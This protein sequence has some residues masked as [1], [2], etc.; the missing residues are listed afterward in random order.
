MVLIGEKEEGG[1]SIK[2]SDVCEYMWWVGGGWWLGGIEG[3]R[4]EEE[5][6]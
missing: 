3:R 4:K 5:G 2:I 1:A 6:K